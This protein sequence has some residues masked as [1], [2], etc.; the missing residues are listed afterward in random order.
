MEKVIQTSKGEFK[1]RELTIEEGM[2]FDVNLQEKD[3][4]MSFAVKCIEPKITLDDFKKLS[5]KE[6]LSLINAANEING[7]TDFQKP[8][9]KD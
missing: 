1:V 3:R 6:G 5:F 7:L 4:A 9:T 8:A 2:D